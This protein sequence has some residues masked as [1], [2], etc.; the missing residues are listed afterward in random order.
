[1]LYY[2]IIKLIMKREILD[3]LN[4][5]NLNC[6]ICSK[7]FPEL[8]NNPKKMS[9]DLA[10]VFE[11]WQKQSK[12]V[13]KY[14]SGEL[15]NLAHGDPIKSHLSR[16]F[17]RT[18]KR[19]IKNNNINKYPSSAG[20]EQSKKVLA[21]YINNRYRPT[22]IVSDENI[23][24]GNSTTY[25][26]NI[27]CQ[28]LLRP[29]DVIVIPSPTYGIF[30]YIPER[31]GAKIKFLE[32]NKNDNWFI[33]SIKLEKLIKQTNEDLCLFANKNNLEYIPRVSMLL[34][35]NPSNPI[36]NY[37]SKD[38]IEDLKVIADICVKN[39]IV[40]VEDLLY[41]GTIYDNKQL[42][43]VMDTNAFPENSIILQGVS[44]AYGLASFRA[45]F[46]ISNNII[47]NAL[48]NKL[49]QNMDSASLLQS[50]TLEGIFG[51]NLPQLIKIENENS[52]IYNYNIKL[53]CAMIYGIN[54]LESNKTKTSIYKDINFVTKNKKNTKKLLEGVRGISIL[55]NSFPKSGFF[56]N[57][58]FSDIKGKKIK[59][60]KINNI[61]DVLKLTTKYCHF[62]FLC[63]TTYGFYEEAMIGRFTFSNNKYEIIDAFYKLDQI[64]NKEKYYETN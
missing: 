63:G 48:R 21:N 8:F 26:F 52:N 51:T 32:L 14:K 19:I 47:I 49:F 6:K 33:N 50:K 37:Y 1:M 42:L 61:Y 11:S 31:Y 35:I 23:I 56:V 22:K 15:I 62:K 58:D 38:N 4:Y 39:N 28:N 41:D 30:A 54:E 40:V 34:M 45:G 27:I 2:D 9:T 29:Y 16:N 60:I 24:I 25:L 57:I 55:E 13:E 5:N 18:F 3:I 59:N 53:I 17:I 10:F 7:H 43:S 46:A 44:K 64:L 36:G 12:I 20:N